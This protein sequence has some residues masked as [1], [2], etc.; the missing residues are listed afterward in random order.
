MLLFWW[1]GP[2][3][4]DKGIVCGVRASGGSRGTGQVREHKRKVVAFQF[5]SKP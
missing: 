3:I 4:I 1:E 5:S 2:K